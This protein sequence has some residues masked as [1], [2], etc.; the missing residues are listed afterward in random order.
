MEPLAHRDLVVVGGGVLGLAAAWVA[1]LRRPDWSILVLE[2]ARIGTGATL[3]SAGLS[4]PIAP[5]GLRE[6]VRQAERGL[7]ELADRIPRGT[8]ASV[9]FFVVVSRRA[10]AALDAAVVGPPFRPATPGDVRALRAAYP[11]LA[12]DGDEVVLDAASRARV[13]DAPRLAASLA[14]LL[15][16]SGRSACWEGARVDAIRPADDGR[17]VR[18]HAGAT[19]AARRVVVATG[20]WAPPPGGDVG[21][22]LPRKRVV[23]LHVDAPVLPRAGVLFADDDLFLLPVPASGYLLA[24]FRRGEPTPVGAAPDAGVTEDHL[25]AGTRVLARRVPSLAGRVVGG[26]AFV[27]AYAPDRAPAPRVSRDRSL[28]VLDG[29]SGSGVRLALGLAE[30]AV[31][32]LGDDD[33]ARGELAGAGLTETA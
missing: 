4:L 1:R 7:E 21:E 25:D 27:D 19:V 11:D 31:G 30:A 24:S 26:R 18:L 23:A 22:D 9:P 32:L 17:V 15:V 8:I 10:R 14:R 20:P 3:W 6:I 28:V 33:G 16:E 29:G 13:V 2:Q 5:T 12:I